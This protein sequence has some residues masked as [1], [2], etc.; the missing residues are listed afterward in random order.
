MKC[1]LKFYVP[2]SKINREGKY[3]LYGR[4]TFKGRKSEFKIDQI[5]PF[6]NCIRKKWIEEDQVFKGNNSDLSRSN[7]IITELKSAF[8]DYLYF[9]R[10]KIHLLSARKIR[11]SILKREDNIQNTLLINSYDEYIRIVINESKTLQLGTKKNYKKSQNHFYSFLKSE[12]LEKVELIDFKRIHANKFKD[13]LLS[14][15]VRLS[16]VTAQSIL[17]NV[18]PFF[19]RKY[20]DEIISR[21]PFRNVYIQ[22]RPKEQTCLTLNEFKR[23]LKQDLNQIPVLEYYRDIFLFMS[24]TGIIYSDLMELNSNQLK[25]VDGKVKIDSIRRKSQITYRQFISQPAIKIINKYKDHPEVLFTGRIV[26][27]RSLNE[28]N[29]N[30][31][32]LST[33]CGI[34]K[35]LT[36]YHARRMF[37]DFID[38]SEIGEGT[39]KKTLMG[40]STAKNIESRYNIINDDKLL[41]AKNK[42][43]TYFQKNKIF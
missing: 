1:T 39:I 23:I 24:Y 16:S 28:I 4:I 38:D 6:E 10:S 30:L 14:E 35:R 3:S 21:D 5:K 12:N 31:R 27:R 15:K 11:D 20:D 32:I 40:H 42:M 19:R 43:D 26:P 13:Y 25:K 29:K 41:K 22:C 33:Y 17:K 2:K 18:K 7:I 34:N 9:N 37:S 36:T 8:S